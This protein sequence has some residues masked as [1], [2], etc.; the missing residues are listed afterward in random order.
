MI[1]Q[2]MNVVVEVEILLQMLGD[3]LL[4]KQ[5]MIMINPQVPHKVIA[6]IMLKVVEQDT[7]L[8]AESV[9]KTEA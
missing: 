6:N 2:P 5:H 1:K 8:V 4:E 9:L 7:S 3:K